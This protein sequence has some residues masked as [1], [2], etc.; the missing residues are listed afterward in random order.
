MNFKKVITFF[1]SAII[2]FSASYV[3][4]AAPFR[5]E[6]PEFNNINVAK[7]NGIWNKDNNGKLVVSSKDAA[8]VDGWYYVCDNIIL[9]KYNWYYFDEKGERKSG[10]IVDKKNSDIWYYVNDVSDFGGGG[11]VTGWLTDP[12][13][14]EK[15]Y[16]D[17]ETGNMCFGWKM[18]GPNWYY[19]GER[20]YADVIW[21]QDANGNWIVGK[22]IHSF[23]TITVMR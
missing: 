20:Q 13:D 22:G 4:M 14:G 11:L 1:I 21:T 10:W 2:I 17:P 15:Y 3:T 9:N 8:L 12:Q 23:G 18:I 16:L 19:F 5:Y 7:V 6:K